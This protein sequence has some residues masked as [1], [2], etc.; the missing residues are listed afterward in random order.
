MINTSNVGIRFQLQSTDGDNTVSPWFEILKV[1][2]KP[3]GLASVSFRT[4]TGTPL[5][6]GISDEIAMLCGGTS[7]GFL[8]SEYRHSATCYDFEYVLKGV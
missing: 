7:L 1:G 5:F 4:S 6:S 3:S 2:Y 8:L